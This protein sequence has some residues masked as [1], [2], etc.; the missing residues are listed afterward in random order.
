MADVLE[1]KV[2]V[3]VASATQAAVAVKNATTTVAIVGGAWAEP[4]RTGLTTSL[5]R[6]A[7]AT[8]PGS[9]RGCAEGLGGKWLQLLRGAGPAA[10]YRRRD[11]DPDNPDGA[12][13]G[14]RA[15]AYR[16]YAGYEAP[17]HRGTWARSTRSRLRAGGPKCPSCSSAP[18]CHYHRAPVASHGTCR[19]APAPDVYYLRDYVDAG[20][21]MSYAIQFRRP[22]AARGG[23]RRQ[24]SN[25]ANPGDLPIEQPTKFELV[26]NLKTAKALGITIPESILL[27][28]DE[29][30]R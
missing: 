3:L 20:G 18:F 28:A 14:E 13:A 4:L 10:L 25:G 27:R 2:D 6:T 8:L 11:H 1:H 30:I 23:L 22:V 26:V 19:Q 16:A 7:A 21:L 29:V 12:R 9:R 5:A 24:N 15:G 17:A